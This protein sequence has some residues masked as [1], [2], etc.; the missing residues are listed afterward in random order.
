MTPGRSSTVAIEANLSG[1][2]NPVA[3]SSAGASPARTDA[4]MIHEFGHTL[5]LPDFCADAKTGLKGLTA[6]VD[7]F[8]ANKTIP[9][10]DIAQ[11]RAIYAVHDSAGH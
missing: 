6:V 8:H 7:D 10:E 3:L 4:V 11:L 9:D 2:H 1:Q 5:G